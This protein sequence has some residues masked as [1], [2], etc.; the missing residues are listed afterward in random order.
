MSHLPPAARRA[1]FLDGLL[2]GLLG[3]LLLGG[4]GACKRPEPSLGS[5]SELRLSSLGVTHHPWL[6][7]ESGEIE[8]RAA[9]ALRRTGKVQV[10]ENKAEGAAAARKREE[11]GASEWR[12]SLEIVQLRIS[13]L[14]AEDGS[15]QAEVAVLLSLHQGRERLRAEG[16]ALERH[17]QEDPGSQKEAFRKALDAALATAADRIV[18]QLASLQKTEEELIADLSAPDVDKRDL[19]IR[20]LT[21]RRSGAAVPI[22]LERLRDPD[23]EIQLRTIGALV[24]IGDLRAA[25]ALVDATAQRDASFVVQVIYALSQLGGADAEAYLFTASTGH[26]EAAVRQAATEALGTLRAQAQ[27]EEPRRTQNL[28]P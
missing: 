7:L 26:P 22:L 19:A 9:T 14:P 17:N 11:A 2:V 21:D 13:P 25:T 3:V 27:A 4:V 23:R 15:T 28:L 8:G 20:M 16:S 12:A 10:L 6:G 18:L 1:K 24:E 5:I